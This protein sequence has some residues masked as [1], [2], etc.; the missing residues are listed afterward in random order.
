MCAGYRYDSN[1]NEYFSALEGRLILCHLVLDLAQQV[2]NRRH[3]GMLL[4]SSVAAV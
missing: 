2:T 3:R 4:Y 1:I